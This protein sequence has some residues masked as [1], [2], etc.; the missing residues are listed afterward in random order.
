MWLYFTMQKIFPK[1]FF[2][3]CFIVFTY[4][5]RWIES[6]NPH[7]PPNISVKH[8][9][10]VRLNI[11]RFWQIWWS[12]INPNLR[13]DLCMNQTTGGVDPDFFFDETGSGL[14][15]TKLHPVYLCRNWIRFICV[16]TGSGLFVSKRTRFLL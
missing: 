5:K 2:F 8:P 16:E 10:K 7:P 3:Y 14:F 13:S 1:I 11:V 6:T 15:L 12:I 4:K 9:T